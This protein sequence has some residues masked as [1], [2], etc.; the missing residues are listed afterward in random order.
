L[1]PKFS[2]SDVDTFLISFEKVAELS[3]FPP[4]KYAAILQPILPGKL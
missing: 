3:N 2:E 4:D 1:V